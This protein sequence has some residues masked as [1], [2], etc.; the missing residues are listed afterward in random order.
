MI[1]FTRC[2]INKSASEGGLKWL[3]STTNCHKV[4]F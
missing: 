2:H 4:L 1:M 3:C